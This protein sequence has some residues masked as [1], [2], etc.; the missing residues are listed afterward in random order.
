M[1]KAGK[2]ALVT[3]IMY[4]LL[5]GG[6]TFAFSYILT[7]NDT[8]LI[9]PI[10]LFFVILYGVFVTLATSALIEIV[11]KILHMA[12]GW[13]IFVIPCILFDAYVVFYIVSSVFPAVYT[14][15]ITQGVNAETIIIVIIGIIVTLLFSV[16]ALISNIRSL[17]D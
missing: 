12:T 7:N 8:V 4:T 14:D 2:F 5:Y 10:A 15:T 6:L 9:T 17:K 11:L 16:G 3:Y 1:K 13:V